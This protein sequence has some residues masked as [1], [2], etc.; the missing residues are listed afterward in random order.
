[1]VMLLKQGVGLEVLQTKKFKD[2]GISIRFRSPL[3]EKS[4][5][6]RSLLAL[7]LCDRSLRYDTKQK[8]SMH[9]DALYGASLNAQTMGYGASHVVDIRMKVINPKYCDNVNL[10]EEIFVF[11]KEILFFPAIREDVFIEAKKMLEAKIKR[12]IDDPA[13]YSI[14]KAL[15]LA[16]E[17]TPLAISSLG[18]SEICQSITL[19]DVERAYYSLIHEDAVDILICGDV[20]EQKV[21]DYVKK[22]LDFAAREIN[23]PTYYAVKSDVKNRFVEENRNISQT[24][25]TMIWFSDTRIVDDDYYPLRVGNAILGQYATSLLFQEVRE[26]NSLCYSIFSNLISYDGALGVTTGIDKQHS[27]KTIALIKEQFE[28]M[29]NGDFSD[30][31]FT[32]SKQMIVNSLRA[33]NDNMASLIALAYQNILLSRRDTTQ[34]IITKINEVTKQQVVDAMAKCRLK[35][36]FLLTKR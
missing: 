24:N 14:S 5:C 30:E 19:Q 21:Q 13:Q 9:L 33:S 16:G 20:E 6:V 32:V 22:Y 7:M 10:N 18:E 35:M 25:I 11:L 4:A 3:D 15:K 26:K 28:R 12:N 34:D 17:G 8:M 36:T 1:M 27:E 2:I 31:L 29:V 23:L